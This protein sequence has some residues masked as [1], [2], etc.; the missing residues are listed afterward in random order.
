MSKISCGMSCCNNHMLG[1]DFAQQR[2]PNPWATKRSKSLR[3]L[4][5]MRVCGNVGN[6]AMAHPKHV[7]HV[8]INSVIH[9]C[10][11]PLIPVTTKLIP[12]LLRCEGN[13]WCTLFEGNLWC[14]SPGSTNYGL[15]EAE[16]LRSP[17][18]SAPPMSG[19]DIPLYKPR[20]CRQGTSDTL[21]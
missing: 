15:G 10:T 6:A 11:A 1:N 16:Q 17:V 20:A 4:D 18:S 13:L 2:S 8:S 5:C 21:Q 3:H 9:S 19:A 7:Q 14:T 12:L